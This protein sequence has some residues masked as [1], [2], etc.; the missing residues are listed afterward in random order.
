MSVITP[1]IIN[2]FGRITGWNKVTLTLFNRDAEAITEIAYDD[3]QEKDN[4]YGAG[5]Y[6]IGQNEGNY[7]PK[8]SITLFSEEVIA[9][10]KS[11]PAGKRIQD[12]PPTDIAVEYDYNGVLIKDII[13]NASF[14]NNGREVKQGDGKI[15]HK[16]DLLTSHI[17]WNI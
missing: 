13:R 10:Q 1:T 7:K 6:P 4:E 17:D 5:K 16:F 12:I 11:I 9:I 15:V 3:E 8:A 14:K 2:K